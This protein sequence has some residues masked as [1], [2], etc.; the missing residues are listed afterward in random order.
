[1]GARGAPLPVDEAVLAHSVEETGAVVMGRYA[2]LLWEVATE[3][4]AGRPAPSAQ[5]TAT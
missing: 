5:V 4:L 1:M 3:M 2:E